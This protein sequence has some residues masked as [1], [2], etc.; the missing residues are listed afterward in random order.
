[1]KMVAAAPS[2]DGMWCLFGQPSSEDTELIRCRDDL[3]VGRPLRPDVLPAAKTPVLRGFLRRL[4]TSS[5][6]VR[7]SVL[8]FWSCPRR[9]WPGARRLHRGARRGAGQAQ[10]HQQSI[11]ATS[12]I[13]RQKKF[14]SEAPHSTML[15]EKAPQRIKCEYRTAASGRRPDLEHFRTIQ[16]LAP[17]S[18]C[19]FAWARPRDH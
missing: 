1:M 7:H 6:K 8:P 13:I 10:G 12:I 3:D 9:P 17:A 16:G 19:G 11:R 5:R 18:V 4:D 2:I 15:T 14:Y